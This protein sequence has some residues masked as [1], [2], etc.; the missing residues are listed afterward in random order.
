MKQSILFIFYFI[1]NFSIGVNLLFLVEK[2]HYL[3]HQGAAGSGVFD[4]LKREAHH[5]GAVTALVGNDGCR[6]IVLA[7]AHQRAAFGLVG[8]IDAVGRL[9]CVE[10]VV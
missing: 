3:T 9:H 5:A 1:F 2:F 4:S 10:F 6:D 8:W 7:V